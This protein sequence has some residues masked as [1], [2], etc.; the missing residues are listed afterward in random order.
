[1]HAKFPDTPLEFWLYFAVVAFVLVGL[2]R[3]S[4]RFYW[5]SGLASLFVLYGGWSSLY[6]NESFR[7]AIIN[8]LGFG[9]FLQ[10]AAAFAVPVTAVVMYGL[11]DF[12]LLKRGRA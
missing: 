7:S 9:Y 2:C 3:L 6:A 11:F 10:Y 5:A 4:R 8:E 1:M 12:R